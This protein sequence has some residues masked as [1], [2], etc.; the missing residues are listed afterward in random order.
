MPPHFSF[1][2][3]KIRVRLHETVQRSFDILGV[4]LTCLKY[5]CRCCREFSRKLQWYLG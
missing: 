2:W 5:S 4:N 1:D 3:T